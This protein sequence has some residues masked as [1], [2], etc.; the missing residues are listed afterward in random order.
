MDKRNEQKVAWLLI[1]SLLVMCFM[2]LP[3]RVKDVE[4][5]TAMT[6]SYDR[7][8]F[9]II[10]SNAK[11]IMITGAKTA[12][13][14]NGE[15]TVPATMDGYRVW[16]IDENAFQNDKFI[17]RV[18]LQEGIESIGVAAF[19]GCSSLESITFPNS[20][21]EIY[22]GAFYGTP[23]LE[24][25]MAAASDGLVIV[26][27][28]LIDGRMAE[29]QVIVPADVVR[30]APYAFFGIE[31]ENG[32]TCGAHIESVL[33]KNPDTEIGVFAFYV[34]KE[35]TS[36]TLPENISVI[37]KSAFRACYSLHSIEIPDTV[38][39][40]NNNAFNACTSLTEVTMSENIDYIGSGAFWYTPWLQTQRGKAKDGLV[41]IKNYLLDGMMAIGDVVI[42]DGV[43]QIGEMA[44]Y[45]PKTT[46]TALA[47]VPADI[48]SVTMPDSVNKIRAG[49]FYQCIGLV[50]VKMSENVTQIR[51]L[52][53]SG[54]NTLAELALP[55]ALNQLSGNALPSNTGLVI[56]V[57]E[58]ITDISNISLSALSGVVI[59]LPENSPLLH[60]FDGNANITVQTYK[61]DVAS[62][63]ATTV[64]VQATTESIS[65]EEPTT[66]VEPTVAD[67]SEQT[68]DT[69]VST[70]EAPKQ[71]EKYKKG[72]TYIKGKY[73][74]LVTGNSTV[75][76]AGATKKNLTSV[77]I[78]AT[79]KLG[80]KVYKVTAVGKEACKNYKKLKS[81][82]I[83]KNVTKVGDGA[84]MNCTSMT[85]ITFG[86]GV[87][88][89]GKKVLYGDKKLKTI[90]IKSKK[91][92]QIGKKTFTKVPKSV[93]ILVP[94][95]KGSAYKK[96]I[97]KAK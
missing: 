9:E 11:I 74:Y 79:V 80:N 26:N 24:N 82:V 51:N 91:L 69:E 59:R 37:D 61:S 47:A 40:I 58:E 78:P 55:K 60:S 7:W 34:C 46:S 87:K 21:T 23:W 27:H 36:V 10:D 38:T 83:G 70:T 62:T 45:G 28:I 1:F 56:T 71:E 5:A 41:I 57:P 44:F 18:V 14:E 75:T 22:Q 73:K 8:F 4:A 76:F 31:Q 88:T 85:R 52:A 50:S 16:G 97:N 17:K 90:T 96:L 13:L 30:I 25:E 95:G 3:P 39:E 64:E 49:A 63:E 32:L 54:C 77:S 84:F 12:D 33:F 93:K 89:I 65:S 6:G 67:V 66:V 72:K 86:T 48:T 68:T 15:L 94:K 92:S 35:L 42:P 53:F 29:G 81:V 20:I 19:E 43:T 2:A